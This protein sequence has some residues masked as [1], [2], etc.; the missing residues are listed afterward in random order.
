ML[1][2]DDPESG[3]SEQDGSK[4]DLAQ[5]VTELL[6]SKAEMLDDYFSLK[7]SDEGDLL[8]LPMLLEN[9]LPQFEGKMK[10]CIR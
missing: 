1:A 5:N 4:T 8:A 3:W 6:T 7:I 2:L 10:K 9:F